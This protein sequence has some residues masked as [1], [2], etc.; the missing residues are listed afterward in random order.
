MASLASPF[1]LRAAGSQRSA[2]A[3]RPIS[4]YK[5]DVPARVDGRGKL[6]VRTVG[7][8]V[9]RAGAVGALPV[10]VVHAR[11]A[12]VRAVDDSLTVRRPD[13]KPV[14]GGV[15]GQLRQPIVGPV[16]DRDL[17]VAAVGPLHGEQLAVR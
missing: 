14:V 15:E 2:A 9:G 10:N 6:V 13:R 1:C 4:A 16:V 11:L 17:L 12:G 7:Q 8:S 5:I 3:P